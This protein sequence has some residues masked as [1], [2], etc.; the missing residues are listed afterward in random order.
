MKNKYLSSVTILTISTLFTACSSTH[1]AATPH[2]LTDNGVSQTTNNTIAVDNGASFYAEVDFPKGS[3][4]LDATDRGAIKD[5]VAK[6]MSRGEVDEIKVLTW[7]D[8]EYPANKNLNVSSR[9]KKIADNRN[10]KI[11]KFLKSTYPA[12]DVTV[13]NMATRSN[14]FQEMFNTSDSRVKTGFNEANANVSDKASKSLILSI[15]KNRQ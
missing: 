7:S 4:N 9:Q 5:L 2:A 10:D 12:I 3:A 8:Q 14:A 1:E 11:K 15:V 13:Y 6:S